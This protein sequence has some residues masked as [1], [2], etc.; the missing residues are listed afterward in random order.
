[1]NSKKI[2]IKYI[3]EILKYDRAALQA[4]GGLK[5]VIKDSALEEILGEIAVDE[6]KHV[7]ILEKLISRLK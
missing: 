5:K 6:K 3:E 1:M 4:Y 2:V 7:E